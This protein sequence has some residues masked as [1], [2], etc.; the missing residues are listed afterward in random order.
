[1]RFFPF[2]IMTMALFAPEVRYLRTAEKGEITLAPTARRAVLSASPLLLSDFV[3][4][5]TELRFVAE[6]E[7]NTR[8]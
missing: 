1:M 7:G 5:L 2:K 4:T 6:V 3:R 8:P